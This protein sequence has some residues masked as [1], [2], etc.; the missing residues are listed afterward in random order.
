MTTRPERPVEPYAW[1]K[2]H[3]DEA[4]LEGWHEYVC[5]LEEYADL[6]EKK[7]GTAQASPEK[8][9]LFEVCYH[10]VLGQTIYVRAKDR[11]E[12]R[13][14]TEAY[15]C[16]NPLSYDDY[17]DSSM[18]IHEVGQKENGIGDEEVIR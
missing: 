7:T 13:T 10:E 4:M 12:A 2:E 1:D 3:M 14:K 9:K 8:E 11:N 15:F 17:I 6:L 5:Q 16:S 18:E